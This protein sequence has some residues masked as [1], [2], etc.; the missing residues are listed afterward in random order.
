MFTKAEPQIYA[1]RV[2]TDPQLEWSPATQSDH[3]LVMKSLDSVLASPTFRSSRRYPAMLRYITEK[4]LEGHPEQLKERTIG[5]EVFGRDA[6]YDTHE[7]PVVRISA[8][9]IRKRLAQFYRDATFEHAI[10]FRLPLGTYVPQILKRTDPATLPQ[11]ATPSWKYQDSLNV[12]DPTLPRARG[13]GM[14]S[15]H[16]PCSHSCLPDG[17][18]HDWQANLT[19]VWW[20]ESGCRCWRIRTL[21]SSVLADQ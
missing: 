4:T 10:E 3:E 11:A 18:I 15:Q 13:F 12:C 19:R 1:L 17:A 8:S 14:G 7:D 2:V 16:V 5:I 6:D 9:E 20:N 21:Y